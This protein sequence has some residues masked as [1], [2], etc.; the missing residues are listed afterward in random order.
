M[1]Y[2]ER[3][4]SVSFSV[5]TDEYAG[6]EATAKAR[7]MTISEWARQAVRRAKNDAVS[8]DQ[9]LATLELADGTA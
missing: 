1:N 2:R 4:R 7:G 5:T 9:L 6:L 8:T 3:H